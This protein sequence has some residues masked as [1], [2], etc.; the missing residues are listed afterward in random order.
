MRYTRYEYKRSNKIKFLC[1]IALIAGVS[2]GGGLYLSNVIF[3]GKEIQSNSSNSGYSTDV[4][5]ES[6]IQNIVV[7]QCGYYSKEE[8]AKELVNSISKYCQPFIVEEDGK[9]RV[10]AGIYKEDDGLKKIEEFK[11]N[12]IDVAKVSLNI[13]KD[14][15]DNKKILEIID[16]FLT[17]RNKLQDNGVKSIK[18]AE[19]KEWADKIL[20]DNG[21]NKSEKLNYIESYMKSLPDEIDKTNSDTNIQQ[22]YKLIKN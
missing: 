9:F 6:N 19:F 7:L 5:Y 12:N 3:N 15:V 20:N 22:L 17:V 14:N 2:I 13:S 21:S 4:N 1:S 8:N 16:G 11:N 18:T 10:L